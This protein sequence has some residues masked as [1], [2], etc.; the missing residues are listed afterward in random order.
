MSHLV[1]L[2]PDLWN[3]P[4]TNP[5]LIL[6]VGRSHCKNA[7]GNFQAIYAVTTHFQILEKPSTAKS[8]QQAE[9]HGLPRA[10]QLSEG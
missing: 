8:A 3:T 6:F 9:L 10:N 4:L 1:I 7:K 2:C 5:G